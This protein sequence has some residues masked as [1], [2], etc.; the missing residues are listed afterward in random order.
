MSKD[1]RRDRE[2][3]SARS[4]GLGNA[5]CVTILVCSQGALVFATEP[6]AFCSGKNY[7]GKFQDIFQY[8]TRGDALES[9]KHYSPEVP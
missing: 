2:L 7:G 4:R 5:S 6:V 9:R 1:K 3:Q 8:P